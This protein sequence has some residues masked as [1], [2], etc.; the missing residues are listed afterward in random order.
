VT[1]TFTIISP[2]GPATLITPTGTIED[3]VPTFIW[4]EVA[5]ATWYK[6]RVDH[7]INGN[8]INTW[9][10][11]ADICDGSTCE[12]APE[13]TLDDGPHTWWVQ[14]W[15]DAGYGP[16][17]DGL[18]FVVGVCSL[19]DVPTLSS[20]TGVI[21]D[22]TPTYTWNED[23]LATWYY[24][25]VDGPLGNIYRQWYRAGDVCDGLTCEVTP[26]EA[27]GDGTYT[28]WL[29]AW[30]A[31]G[32]GPWSPGVEF[33]LGEP[34][35][36]PQPTPIAPAGS[37][38]DNTPTYVW[39]LLETASWY[40]LWV[41]GPAGH[42]LDQWYKAKDVC[43]LTGCEVTPDLPLGDGDYHWWLR[44]WNLYGNGPWS[45]R[46]DFTLSTIAGAEALPAS[47]QQRIYLPLVLKS[48]EPGQSPAPPASG[49]PSEADAET[50]PPLDEPLAPQELFQP[51]AAPGTEGRTADPAI[52][53][54][55]LVEV[56][57][58]ALVGSDGPPGSE[59][60]SGN[61][62]ALNLFE[63]AS[64]TATLDHVE[65][66]PPDRVT[67]LGH[68]AGVTDSRVTFA[69]EDERLSG[70]ITLPGAVYQVRYAGDGLYAIYEI[71]QN[72]LMP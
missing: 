24:L 62:L 63:D 41:D 58:D 64:F 19:P 51:A 7:K 42:V 13:V 22:T 15:N 45:V 71:N 2:P 44:G 68:I 55:R 38:D 40:Y 53:R 36:P 39:D 6:L 47:G 65:A 27:L 28:W 56:D 67:W 23:P 50:E 70:D 17:S 5:T 33:T 14:T 12:A 31:C 11:A 10:R 8:V 26:T 59:S 1:A 29:R 9:F 43:T 35:P 20:P 25:W 34:V 54:T 46:T 21:S 66:Q 72:V 37:I 3:N 30:N 69:L 61:A 52:L 49:P 4:H 18:S 57:F 32:N 16:W 48:G 60:G